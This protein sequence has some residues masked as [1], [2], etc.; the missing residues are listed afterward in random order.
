MAEKM[1]IGNGNVAPLTYETMERA[2]D[3]RTKAVEAMKR[4]NWDIANMAPEELMKKLQKFYQT[5]P[6]GN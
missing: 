4:E 3:S 1:K 6:Q 2:E 5:K